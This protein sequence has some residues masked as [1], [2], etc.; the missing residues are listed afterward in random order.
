[1][2]KCDGV[3][4]TV[5]NNQHLNLIELKFK[6]TGRQAARETFLEQIKKK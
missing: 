5:K 4:S 2:E 6:Q 1:M 3:Y